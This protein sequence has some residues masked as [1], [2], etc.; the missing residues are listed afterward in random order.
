MP[1][2][3]EAFDLLKSAKSYTSLDIHEGYHHFRIAVGEE[4]NT[5]FRTC[6]GLYKYNV[7]PIGLTNA[8]TTFQ[9]WLN[10]LLS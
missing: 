6:A 7:L 5:A 2:I 4:W 9:R 8:A 1:L 10:E 3:D